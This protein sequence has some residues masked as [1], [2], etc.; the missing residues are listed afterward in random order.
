MELEELKNIWHLQDK[1]DPFTIN[2]QA[3]NNYIQHKKE[4]ALHLINISELLLIVVN[5]G[6]GL[7]TILVNKFRPPSEMFLYVL[8]VWMLGTALYALLFRI[9]RTSNANKFDRS[10]RGD[11]DYAVSTATHQVKLSRIMRWNVVPIA[12]L[13]TLV[14]WD[15]QKSILFVGGS[16]FFFALAFYFSGWEHNIYLSK[17]AALEKLRNRL[18]QEDLSS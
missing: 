2:M 16:I 1:Q 13:T 15:G 5:F 3:M 18:L 10:I 12:L 17:K 9:K 8:G 6:A 7:F 11:L 14:M 4:K